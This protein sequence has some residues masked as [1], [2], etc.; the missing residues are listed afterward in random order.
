MKRTALYASHRRL[1]AAL[2]EFAGWEMPVSYSGILAEAQAVRRAAGL[3]DVSH[4]GVIEISGAGARRAVDGWVT[5]DVASLPEGRARYGLLLNPAGGIL[6]DLLIYSLAPDRLWIIANAVNA[7]SDLARAQAHSGAGGRLV[8][9]FGHI[10]ILA[11]QGPRALAIAA[12][13]TGRD[14]S[15]LRRYGF[16]SWRADDEEWLASRTGYT[17]EDG[18][19]FFCP[20]AAA[21]GL[22]DRLLA[23]GADRGLVPCG[24]GA[25][26]VLRIEAG[27]VLYGHEI[28]EET[29]P[30]EANLM[31]AVRLE[32]GDFIG[33]DA[34]R[35]AQAAEPARR[36]A[37]LAMEERAIPR[38][39]APVGTDGEATGVV[40][41]GTFSPTLDRAIALAYLP[42]AEGAP[43]RP[44]WVALRG[45]RRRARTTSLP[46]FRHPRQE[47]S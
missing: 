14:F 34:V 40:T 16:A 10:A 24:L 44:A 13:A 26:D 8:P 30:V 21:E 42:L 43:G 39:G 37:G 19:E 47:G 45:K 41:S 29:T 22:W 25:R 11:L 20:A 7:E 31:W 15:T 28:N 46:F 38:Q 1:N 32:K 23:A 4:M 33:R 12:D 17:G 27:N 36:L 2:A 3:F 18:L 5:C 35:R 6:D 9:H